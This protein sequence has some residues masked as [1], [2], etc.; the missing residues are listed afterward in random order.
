MARENLLERP[1]GADA[2][3]EA[4]VYLLSARSV[5]GHNLFVDAGQR[6]LKRP[7]DVMFETVAR[8]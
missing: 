8:P 5:T 3:A 6:F 1:V 2:I 7:G 4:V